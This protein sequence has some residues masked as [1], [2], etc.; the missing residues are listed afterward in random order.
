M[1]YEGDG[2]GDGL[3]TKEQYD[4]WKEFSARMAGNYP[5]TTEARRDKI[6]KEVESFFKAMDCNETWKE[7]ECWDCADCSES[8]DNS[9]DEYRK[10]NEKNGEYDENRFFVQIT[11]SIRAAFDIAVKQS[12]GVVGFTAGDIRRIWG[13]DVP[14]W[15]KEH[16]INFDTIPDDESV[17]M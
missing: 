9:F 17:W 15:V 10:W 12:G 14:D 8:V 4:R 1:G 16:Y 13:G 5:N 6:A 11:C 7:I 3:M 2:E